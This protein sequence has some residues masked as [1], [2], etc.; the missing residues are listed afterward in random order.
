MKTHLICLTIDTDPDGLSG[1][2]VNR[3]RLE[4]NALEQLRKLPAWL[5]SSQHLKDW[6]IPVTWFVRADDQIQQAF[7]DP[8]D[9][10]HRFE[11]L[12]SQAADLGHEL[13][14]HPHLYTINPHNPTHVEIAS[15]TIACDQIVRVWQHVQ[16]APNS[17]VCFRNG[18]GWHTP[19]TFDCVEKLGLLYDSTAIPGR[20]RLDGH[21]LNWQHS[22]N[23]P[24]FPSPIDI[25]R[26]IRHRP[27]LEL[28][29]NTWLVQ[30]PYDAEP[31]LRYMAPGVHPQIF[32]Q[33]LVKWNAGSLAASNL[34]VWVL[35]CHP[36]EI[37]P[38]RG[39]DKLFARSP[40]SLCR[41][42]RMLA[43]HLQNQGHQVEFVSLRNAGERWKSL[44]ES[45]A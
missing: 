8:M 32:A 33:S 20:R 11:N 16:K 4:F 2:T 14:W 29:L 28:P 30:A 26:P 21:P 25:Q 38:L 34:H 39:P 42:L 41:N 45:P 5:H 13:G 17:I 1:P 35:I 6:H 19:A 24:W 23:Q 3:Q 10:F 9:I 31:K 22:E 37:V 44:L 7:G 18:E 43:C 36:D 12:F 40:D 27:L 15:E